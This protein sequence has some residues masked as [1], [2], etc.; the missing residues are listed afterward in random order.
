MLSLAVKNLFADICVVKTRRLSRCGMT[1]PNLR[2]CEY[3][4]R[5]RS[6]CNSVCELLHRDWSGRSGH[7]EE[8]SYLP[9]ARGKSSPVVAATCRIDYAAC[10]CVEFRSFLCRVTNSR[11]VHIVRGF[12]WFANSALEEGIQ[13]R[14]PRGKLVK[15]CSSTHHEDIA[16]RIDWTGGCCSCTCLELCSTQR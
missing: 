1:K 10:S 16:M 7:S 11:S 9:V 3:I 5:P 8:H 6:R 2:K 12:W 15:D 14:F 4:V 13:C